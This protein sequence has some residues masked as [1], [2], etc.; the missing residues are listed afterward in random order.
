VGL[1]FHCDAF[2]IKEMVGE[3]MISSTFG[4]AAVPEMRTPGAG[5]SKP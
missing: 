4:G 2:G 1:S 5:A 3:K